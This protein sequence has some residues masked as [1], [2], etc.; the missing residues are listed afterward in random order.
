MKIATVTAPVATLWSRPDAPR[1][2]VDAAVLGPHSD[3]RSWVAGLDD[4]GRMYHGVL[5]QL[6]HGEQVLVEE[7]RGGWARVVATAQPAAKLDP[8]GYPGWLPLDQ[9][10]VRESGDGAAG[11]VDR[12][13]ALAAARAWLGVT[14]VWG[15]LTPYGIDCSGLV[16]LAFRQLGVT[17]P[18]D[19]SDQRLAVPELPLGSEQPGDLYF[20]ADARGDIDHVGFV[21]AA[22][23]DGTRFVLH[24]CSVNGRV[25]LEE[26]PPARTA[27]LAGAG[28]VGG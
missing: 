3:P 25:I 22:P 11:A 14:Y 27:A 9:L 12:A 5:T 4:E 28:R 21:A 26:M 1:P 19:A 8:R 6:L 10:S 23:R 20:F 15:G 17:V 7:V 13:A 18:R 24:A 16:H 2:G